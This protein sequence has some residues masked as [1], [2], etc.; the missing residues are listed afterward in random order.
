MATLKDLASDG[1]DDVIDQGFLDLNMA[2][3]YLIT[4]KNVL[5]PNFPFV[6][7]SPQTSA[8]KLRLEKPFLFFAILASSSFNNLTLQRSLGAQV[9]NVVGSRVVIKGE[10]TFDLLQGLLVYLA[11]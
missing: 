11:W 4:F 6:V 8:S 1:S 10:V 7:V 5:A 9:K 3:D 2:E